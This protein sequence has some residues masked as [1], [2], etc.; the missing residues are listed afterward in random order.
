M[1]VDF[2]L[3]P[4]PRF[5]VSTATEGQTVFSV[6]FPWQANSDIAVTRTGLDGIEHR[7]TYGVDYTLAGVGNPAGGSLTLAVPCM[8]GEKILRLGQAGIRRLT[9]VVRQGKFASKAIDDDFDRLTLIAQELSRDRARSIRVPLGETPPRVYPGAEGQMLAF[10][11]FGNLRPVNPQGIAWRG[12]WS[13]GVAYIKNDIVRYNQ[14]NWIARQDHTGVTPAPGAYW[15]IFIPA[16][17]TPPAGSVTGDVLALGAVEEKHVTTN[18]ADPLRAALSGGQFT[19]QGRLTLTAG[20]AVPETGATG[21]LAIHY[22]PSSGRLVPV[23][24]GGQMKMRDMGA[25]LTLQLDANPGHV[26]YHAAGFNYDLFAAWNGSA[27]VL[28]TGP[29]WA[30]GAGSAGS[31]TARGTGAN[32]TALHNTNG[33][34]VNA[35]LIVMRYG[36]EAGDTMIVPAG[37]ATYLGSFRATGNGLASDT[38]ARRLLFNAYN[39]VFRQLRYVHST[40]SWTYSDAAYRVAGPTGDKAQVEF[41]YGLLGLMA[42]AD[43]NATVSSD[44]YP[45]LVAAYASIGLDVPFP[46]DDVLSATA[47]V[48]S[49]VTLCASYRGYPGLGYH[50]LAKLEFGGGTG[51]QTWVGSSVKT[52]INGWVL[53]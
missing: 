14:T 6:P 3:P 30:A 17:G 37:E 7:L 26:N 16:A 31:N 5:R 24:A 45:S 25:G 53:S 51:T 11:Q 20:V 2:P 38:R 48:G 36:P 41:L 43:A 15:E 50:T 44:T 46:N 49:L 1:S 47:F 39:Q 8:A 28:G 21:Q 42:Q 10:D 35:N 32:S 33:L 9:S 34:L 27:L 13:N 23:Y 22:V 19:P 18:P 12:V 40:L 29:S 52:G 4:D